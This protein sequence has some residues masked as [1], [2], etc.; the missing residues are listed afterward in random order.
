[1]LTAIVGILFGNL[2][3]ATLFA[4]ALSNLHR[5]LTK[6]ADIKLPHR[7]LFGA[8]QTA[9]E[10]QQTRAQAAGEFSRLF[11][12]YAMSFAAFKRVGGVFVVAIIILA[13]AVA[14]QL[15]CGVKAFACWTILFVST[16][17]LV[18][19]FLQRAIAPSPNQLISIDFL[20][21]NFAN[22]HMSSLLNSSSL[23]I[24]FGRENLG[25]PVMHFNIGQDLMFSGYRFLTAVSNP[26][27]SRV[28][29][30]AYGLVGN[31]VNFQQI[32]TPEIQMF[33]TP[34]GDFS[35][36]DAM[37]SSPLLRLHSWLFVPTPAGW[38]RPKKLHP[39]ILSQDV[40]DNCGGGVGIVLTPTNFAWRQV[41]E[42]VEFER[43]SVLG[44]RSWKI[45]R[46]AVVAQDSPQRI[47]RMY[48]DV[49]ERCPGIEYHDYPNGVMVKD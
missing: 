43:K 28:F 40:T 34:L 20:Q 37:L 8:Q 18:G 17:V 10:R 1:M 12:E 30:V 3:V 19:V 32:W 36:A 9:A 41:D 31:A 2:L 24:D 23:H 4:P 45:T 42:S 13:C 26:E 11:R 15:S 22:L 47:L 14:W 21:N 16:I 29:F 48:R 6:F 44:L 33:S 35:L 7:E 38:T 27:C 25:D 46:L 5:I 39:Q 49:V